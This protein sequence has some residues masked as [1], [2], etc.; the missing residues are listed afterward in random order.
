MKFKPKI[1]QRKISNLHND[2]VWYDGDIAKITKSNGTK[3]LLIATGEIRIEAKKGGIVFDGFKERNSGI[4]G[5]FQNDL[6]LKKIGNNYT[7]KYRW[8]NNNWFEVIY[9]QKVD[10]NWDSDV[11]NVVYDYDEAIALLE[12]YFEDEDY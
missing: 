1:I 12:S 4:N 9:M 11:G 3:L 6:D 5:G 2:S 10:S 8:E 7:D